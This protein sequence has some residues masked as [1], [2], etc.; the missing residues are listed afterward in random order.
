MSEKKLLDHYDRLPKPANPRRA[1]DGLVD[2]RARLA[3]TRWE[4]VVSSEPFAHLMRA[5]AGNSPFLARICSRDPEL[6]LR[7]IETPLD[8]GFSSAM[9]DFSRQAQDIQAFPDL[10]ALARRAKTEM[11]LRTALADL[12]GL[13]PLE[14]VTQ[15]LTSFADTVLGAGVDWL[16]KQAAS[17]GDIL[18]VDGDAAETMVAKSGLVILAMGKY[19]SGELNYSSDI[20]IVVFYEPGTLRLREGLDPS[21]FFVRLT[22]DLVRL[23]QERTEDGYVFRT[24]LRLRPDPGGSQVAVSLLAAEQYYESRGQNWERAAFIKA[25]VAAGDQVAGQRFL[26][27]LSPFI[28]RKYLDYAAIDDIHSMKRQIHS[29]GGHG[30][31]AVAGHNI[32]LGRGGIREIEFFVQTQQL[33]AG[34][35]DPGLRG[36]QT[37]VMLDVLAEKGWIE[38]PV[39]DDL[40]KAYRF[41]RTL[42]H[43]LQMIDDEQTHLLPS[44]DE[45]LAHVAIFMGYEG[46]DSFE[47]DLLHHL[48]NVQERYRALF[49]SAPPLGEEGGSL[50]FT[51]TDD[52]PDTIKTLADLGFERPSDVANTIR[53]WH[54]G[55]YAATRSPRTR[56]RLT[57]L[58]PELLRALSR[59]ADPDIAFVRF[60]QFLAGL[61]AGVQL[62][63]MLYANPNLLNLIAGICGTAP[64]LASYLSQN[65]AVF[66]AVLTTNFYA[67]LPGEGELETALAEKMKSARDYQDVLDLVRVWAREH[68]FRVGVRILS[69]S[70]N[71]REAGPAYSAI[72][73]ALIQQIFPRVVDEVAVRHGTLPEG[74][75]AIIALGKLGS[76]EMS[77]SSD[78]DIIAVY[79]HPSTGGASDGNKPLEP[80][81]YY[82]RVTKKLV[83]ALTVPTTE[84]KLYEVD[85]RLRPSGNAGPVATQ[86]TSFTDYQANEAWTWEHMA[87]TRARVIAGPPALVA[88]VEKVIREI[89][90]KSRDRVDVAADVVNMRARIEKEFPSED[91]WELKHVRGGLIDL[92]FIAQ[93]LQLICAHDYPDILTPDTRNVFERAA[94]KGML[95]PDVA[96]VLVTAFDLQHDLVQ[97]IRICV[98]GTLNPDMA[99]E[100]LKTRL[101]QGGQAPDF[102]VLEATLKEAQRDVA[103]AFA[104]IIGAN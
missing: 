55:R 42:E 39:V 13:W 45:G 80:S 22:K 52:D 84:G 33:I 61:P 26:S 88:K 64:R 14:T 94:E 31:I 48:R 101:A 77:T 86:L 23:M 93:F 12:S 41:L 97:I 29:V 54:T 75:M 24:D 100:G 2:L 19:G 60:D 17:K 34:G 87:L 83:S 4:S 28:W 73:T 50:V 99:S 9:A 47:R 46:R 25:R 53:T 63:S 69:E 92:E 27:M 10:M 72:A 30:E 32:K 11:A 58:M 38:T 71:A 76:E 78:L 102:A 3:G 51:G 15:N 57:A 95:S 49:E 85:L 67:R 44:T 37:C 103:V 59:T 7:I 66:D 20:D 18:P 91:P 62:F 8:E 90:T 81:Q 40:Q 6:L 1:E 74:E 65:A 70:A 5:I 98:T 96:A 82:A 36:T 79:D 104:D 43:R 35:R 56:E 68:R 16:L 89:L 21:T